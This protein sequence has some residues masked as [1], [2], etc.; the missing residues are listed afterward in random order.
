[1]ASSKPF[2][3]RLFGYQRKAVDAHLAVVDTSIAE[4]QAKV[5]EASSPEH[6]DLV[7]RATR[8]SVESVLEAAEADA[9]G[10]RA[11]ARAEAEGIV[12]DAYELARATN[13]SGESVIDLTEDEAALFDAADADVE[14]TA[15]D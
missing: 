15:A 11:A 2:K 6:H 7:L 14:A 1:M 10:I 3:R 9:E 12:A 13:R 8:L 4:L 5:D